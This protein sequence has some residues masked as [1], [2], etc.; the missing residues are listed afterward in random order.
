MTP[1]EHNI[2]RTTESLHFQR[3]GGPEDYA[4]TAQSPVRYVAV[5]NQAGLLGYLWGADGE[6]A[7]GFEPAPAAGPTAHNASVTWM[8]ALRQLKQQGIPPSQAIAELSKLP[9][10]DQVGRVVP[11]S[12]NEAP[13]SAALKEML[14]P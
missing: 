8:Q 3:V 2:K 12:A 5:A 11:D 9:G 14:A 7:A 13:N 4:Y 6:D 1:E 10:N